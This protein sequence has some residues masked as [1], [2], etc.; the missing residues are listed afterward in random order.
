MSL[1]IQDRFERG[2]ILLI[3]LLNVITERRMALQ[4]TV[5]QRT[6]TLI[7]LPLSAFSF[8]LPLSFSILF[9]CL[10]IPI[11]RSHS[12]YLFLPPSPYLALPLSRSLSFTRSPISLSLFSALYLLLT[13]LLV[14][15]TEPLR[16][17]RLIDCY[18]CKE[19]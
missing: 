14:S 6:A 7:F 11:S 19:S 2:L 1:V 15:I 18:N 10:S 9:I 12:P 4:R 16:V 17:L 13:L 8:C 3:S 5:L